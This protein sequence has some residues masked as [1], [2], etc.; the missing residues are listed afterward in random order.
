M[1]KNDDAPDRLEPRSPTSLR[2]APS[3]RKPGLITITA[4]EKTGYQKRKKEENYRTALL[5][6]DSLS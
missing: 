5:T 6:S 2:L 3:V 4:F 1:F